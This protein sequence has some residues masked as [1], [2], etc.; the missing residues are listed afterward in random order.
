MAGEDFLRLPSGLLAGRLSSALLLLI[1]AFGAFIAGAQAAE[2]PP[3]GVNLS[4]YKTYTVR[5]D[6]LVRVPAQGRRCNQVRVWQALPTHRPWSSVP[7]PGG[8]LDQRYH[9]A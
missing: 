3:R 6:T 7:A 8:A 4:N 9:P 2:A 5:Q 1:S